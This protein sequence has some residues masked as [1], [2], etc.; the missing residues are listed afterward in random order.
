MDIRCAKCGEPWDAYGIRNGDMEKPDA[1]RFE[2]GEGCPV[3]RFGTACPGCS[4][5]GRVEDYRNPSC[6]DCYGKGYVLAWSPRSNSG[7]FKSGEFYVG[8][9]P[10]V[11]H[12]RDPGFD[13]PVTLGTRRFPEK[14]RT[15]RSRDG[16][17][18]DWWIVGYGDGDGYGNGDGDGDGA[19]DGKPTSNEVYATALEILGGEG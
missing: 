4:G 14:I 10:D 1:W 15:F 16:Y 13:S 12:V 9:E 18:D 3:C 7:R 19:G 8:Y 5:T 2:H 11:C 6:S 17:V